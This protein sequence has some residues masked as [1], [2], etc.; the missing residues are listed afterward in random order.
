M[1]TPGFPRNLRTAAKP[2]DTREAK[3]M[4]DTT[5]GLIPALDQDGIPLNPRHPERARKLVRRGRAEP[6]WKYGLYAIR[7][8]DRSADQSEVHDHQVNINPGSKT[9]GLA[10]TA[11]SC[12]GRRIVSLYCLEHRGELVN[13]KLI[14]RSEQ[15]RNQRSRLRHRQP[16]FLNRR[17]PPG[18]LPPSILSRRQNILTWM[19]RVSRLHP[20][21]GVRIENAKFDTQKMVNPNIRGTLYRRGTIWGT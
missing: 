7:M 20:T 8:L 12:G 1:E 16:R 3:K 10:I 4:T 17:R 11:D 18:W 5:H 14:R 21:F 6:C 13:K 15:R 2:P 9:T 19:N